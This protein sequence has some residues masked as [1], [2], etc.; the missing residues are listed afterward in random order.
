M[1]AKFD[2][3][4][5]KEN[6]NND[7]LIEIPGEVFELNEKNFENV[8]D[9]IKYFKEN[10]NNFSYVDKGLYENL[11]EDYKKLIHFDN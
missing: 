1:I 7:E 2:K 9:S 10:K 6:D 4:I 8:N 11:D 5:Q 3:S